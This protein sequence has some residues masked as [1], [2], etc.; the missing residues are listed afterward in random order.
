MPDVARERLLNNDTGAYAAQQIAN[1]D[2]GTPES[3]VRQMKV[4]TMVYSGTEDEYPLPN[5]HLMSKRSASLAP[6][7]TFVALSG[8]DH[9]TAFQQSAV[10][11]PHVREFL[12]LTPA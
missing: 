1:I 5:N 2:W 11:I 9:T 3:A 6:N 7:A 10:V 4:R 8:H 12:G